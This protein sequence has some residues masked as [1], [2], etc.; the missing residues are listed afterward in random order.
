MSYWLVPFGFGGGFVFDLIT[1]L[2]TFSWAGTPGNHIIGGLAGA[3]AAAMGS[4][5]VGGGI[6]L[7]IG[8][9]EDLPY[10][11]RLSAGKYLVICKDPKGQWRDLAGRVLQELKPESLQGYV[12]SGR[13]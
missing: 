6:G 2:D 7:S 4:V 13:V 9:R 1:G 12:L 8:T 11:D 5:F 10:R 3:I